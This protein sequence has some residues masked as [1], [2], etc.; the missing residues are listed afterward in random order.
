MAASKKLWRNIFI[1]VGVVIVILTIAKMSGVLGNPD[2]VKVALSK[3][4]QQDII[5]TVSANG[6]VQPE[7]EV[8]IAADVSGEVVDL[9]VKE[10]QLVK[11]GMLLCRIDPEIYISGME[12]M[13]ASL[14]GSKAN[15][16]NSRSRMTQSMSQFTKAEST[17]KRNKKLFD[18]AVISASD[19]ESIQSSYEVAKAEVEAAKQSVA[20]ADYN[21][22]STEASLKE[23]KENLNKTSI[24]APV[25]GTISKLNIE[26]GERVQG[27]SGFQGTELLRI[28]NLNEMEVSVDVSE[29]DIVRVSLNDTAN[30]DI[31]AYLDRKFKGIVTEVANSANNSTLS[32]TD[33]VTNFTVKIRILHESYADLIP[34]D[35]PD[36]SPFRPGMSATV[37]IQTN[38]VN[39]VL[40]LPIQAVTT[41]DTTSQ[42]SEKKAVQTG[43]PAEEKTTEATT[44]KDLMVECVFIVENGKAKMIP[45]KT[46]VQDS[47][48]IEIKSGV[49]SGESV[50]SAPYNAISKTLKTGTVVKV[51]SKEQLQESDKKD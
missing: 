35:K 16:E 36:E 13:V 15:L 37:E 39:N 42:K 45:V 21:V 41:R 33:Q 48:F 27:V 32:S 7:V 20:A 44:N 17:Y 4:T 50:I 30:I 19:W 18:D 26:Q 29:N 1:A 22:K 40:G 47:K 14:N 25:D 34:K 12:R 10:G 5:E 8:K 28:A 31:D 49:K 2:E 46:G 43:P 23:A 3:V 38:S 11:K 24:Y 51:V 9:F 6:K